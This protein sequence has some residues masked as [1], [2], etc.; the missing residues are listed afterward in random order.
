MFKKDL[1]L[2]K[3]L[4][5]RYSFKAPLLDAG[6]LPDPT[7]ADYD[8]SIN[9]ALKVPLDDGRVVTVPHKE[10]GDRY[11]KLNRPWTF[12]DKDYLIL[13]PSFGDPYIEDLPIKYTD[14][15]ETV[16]L[17][18]VFEHVSD[19]KIVSDALF[20]IVKP[21]GYL[22]NSTPFLFPY[23]PS[24]EDNWRFSPGA[25][26]RI[27]KD[28]GF[29]WLE[30]DFHIKINTGDGVGDLNPER[31]AQPQAIWASYALCRKPL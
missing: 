25:L 21:G 1:D 2:I 10:Q 17:V 24:P 19:P 23:H 11:L 12:I 30:G 7:I 13:N 27:H 18:S 6:G 26:K 5:E 31:Y 29:E 3:G 8:I 22:I 14:Y 20:K 28:S 16:I 9:K 4:H 15:F